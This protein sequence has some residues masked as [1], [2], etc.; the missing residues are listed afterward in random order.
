[1][2]LTGSHIIG[3]FVGFI[4]FKYPA[5]RH[6][7]LHNSLKTDRLLTSG[8]KIEHVPII[9]QMTEQEIERALHVVY[10]IAVSLVIYSLN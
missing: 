4:Q 7:K 1:M 8:S 3:L 10:Q 9:K 6:M 2:I 5:S